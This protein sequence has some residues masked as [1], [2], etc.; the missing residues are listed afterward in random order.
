M[1]GGITVHLPEGGLR[2]FPDADHAE[3]IVDAGNRWNLSVG[4]L[5]VLKGG[6]LRK[7]FGS[8]EWRWYERHL[9]RDLEP[10]QRVAIQ[11]RNGEITYVPGN[12]WQLVETVSDRRGPYHSWVVYSD[13]DICAVFRHSEVALGSSLQTPGPSD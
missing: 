8:S 2:D 6:E 7:A 4:C 12:R 10:P 5:A 9:E 1:A 13:K 3:R 11:R